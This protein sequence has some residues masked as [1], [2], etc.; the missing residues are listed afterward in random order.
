MNNTESLPYIPAVSAM[1]TRSREKSMFV[2]KRE[3][4]VKIRMHNSKEPIS[5]STE[6]KTLSNP[7]RMTTIKFSL[8]LN[9]KI[10]I[11]DYAYH[12]HQ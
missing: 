9:Q 5:S 6:V 1:E 3:A 4:S 12:H 8:Y 10:K 11:L 2:G 7:T